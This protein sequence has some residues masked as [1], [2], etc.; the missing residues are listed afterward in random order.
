MKAIPWFLL[1]FATLTACTAAGTPPS[2]SR[3]KLTSTISSA[4]KTLIPS[5]TAINT[6]TPIPTSEPTPTK[7][8]TLTPTEEVE[9]PGDIANK[10]D[11]ISETQFI[12]GVDREYSQSVDGNFLIETRK[13]SDK[14]IK[15]NVA[16]WDSENGS[17]EEPSL[18]EK[19]AD[20]LPKDK[21][22]VLSDHIILG[23]INVAEGNP[24]Y[25]SFEIRGA[26]T[27]EKKLVSWTNPSSGEEENLYLFK[28]AFL[29]KNQKALE[30]DVFLGAEEY[31]NAKMIYFEEHRDDG[32]IYS[33][34]FV[35]TVEESAEELDLGDVMK[36]TIPFIR[37]KDERPYNAQ[38]YDRP[39]F[40]YCTEP[41][42]SEFYLF[43]KYGESISALQEDL[44]V[45]RN[46]D[47]NV[48]DLV[49]PTGHM[50]V[51]EYGLGG[52]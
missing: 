4:V 36:L 19:Y 29:D 2:T 44:W 17:W 23:L 27:G 22:Y 52:E 50:V 26:V 46:V 42:Q 35:G 6:I 24:A 18:N 25:R 7:E 37:P 30:L 45:G 40:K 47:V 34:P 13:K 20:L 8:P 16:K 1:I 5:P 51:L 38:C 11:W 14:E 9:T 31:N 32:L 21:T 49:I 15:I 41:E 43:Q 3:T 10:L 33:P 39:W 48:N 28:V 12:P